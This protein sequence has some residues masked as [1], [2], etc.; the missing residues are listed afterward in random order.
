MRIPIAS[1]RQIQ[2]ESYLSI[3]RLRMEVG[4]LHNALANVH[5]AAADLAAEIAA[6]PNP[7]DTPCES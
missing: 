2:I 7:K 5:S 4:D 1:E 6:A 3:A